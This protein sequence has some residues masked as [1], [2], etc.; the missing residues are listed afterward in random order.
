MNDKTMPKNRAEEEILG[1]R[2]VLNMIH[3]NYEYISISPNYILQLHNELL[4]YTTLTYGGKFKTTPNEITKTY[5]DG[6]KEILFKQLEPFEVPDAMKNLCEEYNKCLESQLVDPL[7]LIPCFILDFLCIHP[8]NDGNGRI[9]RLLTL[10]L[11]Y[12]SGFIVGK[13]IS[14]EKAIEETKDDYYEA[15][16]NSDKD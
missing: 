13:Y 7:I 5:S 9:S 15:L 2:N 4:K 11:L 14:I 16:Y 1:Y 12:K 10:L 6:T 3:E 8:F